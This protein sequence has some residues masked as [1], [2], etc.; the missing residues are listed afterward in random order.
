MHDWS[1]S[2]LI[3]GAV[4][5]LSPPQDNGRDPKRCLGSLHVWSPPGD[6]PPPQAEADTRYARLAV[7]LRAMGAAN[8]T[9]AH[10]GTV[11]ASPPWCSRLG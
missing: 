7:V 9:Q 2:W 3:L 6:G 11:Q 10:L 1:N 4:R 5:I 8:S